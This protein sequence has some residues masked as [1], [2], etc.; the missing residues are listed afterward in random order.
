MLLIRRS[1]LLTSTVALAAVA[2]CSSDK[3]ADGIKVGPGATAVKVSLTDD[4]CKT[5]P[6]SVPAGPTTFTI[7][8]EGGG[9]VSEAELMSGSKILGEKEGLTPGL[10]GSFS[11]NLAAGDYEMY[12]PNAKTERSPFTVTGT[13]ASASPTGSSAA[14]AATAGYSRY[15]QGKAAELVT[16]TGQFTAAVKA[17]QVA[18]AKQLYAPARAPYE[19]IE[20]VAESFGDLDPAIDAREGDVPAAEW[21]GYHRIEKQLWV[22]NDTAG[23][24][25]VADKLLADV[26][27]LQKRIA[28]TSF[29]A[30]DLANGATELLTEVGKTK[31]AGEEERY[32]GTDLSDIAANL[33]GSRAAFDLLAPLLSTTPDGS[34]TVSTIRSRFATVDALLAK[35]AAGEGNYRPY[36]QLTAPAIRELTVAVDALAEP[37]SQV[38]EQVVTLS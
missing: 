8:N 37:L 33:A 26:K 23:M 24:A 30:A 28:G 9:G 4:G 25:P 20:P 1:A 12:C 21:G 5:E 11:L 18:K 7:K 22:S 17:G 3:D 36:R 38:G 32:S 15:L 35:H 19:A 31:L 6:A 13:A 10:S 16:L 27:D 2:G 34:G 14:A 29:Q